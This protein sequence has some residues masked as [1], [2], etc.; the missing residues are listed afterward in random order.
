MALFKL[1]RRKRESSGLFVDRS[2][3]RYM[4]LSGHAGSYKVVRSAAG[5]LR[6][7]FASEGGSFADLGKRL[8]SLFESIVNDMGEIRDP[9]NISLPIMD[10]LLRTVSLGDMDLSEAKLAFRY[11]HEKYFPFPV[12]EA[13]YDMAPILYPL[14]NGAEEKRFLVASARRTLIDDIMNAA[15]AQGIDIAS[16]EPAQLALERAATPQTPFCDAAVY[17]YAGLSYSV[18]ILSWKGNGI[19]YRSVLRG[20]NAA[21]GAESDGLPDEETS[22][23]GFVKEINSSMQFALSQI[24]GFEPSMMF[25]FGPGVSDRLCDIMKKH[26][27]VASVTTI[28][29]LTVHGIDFQKD[30]ARA[31][32][33]EIPVGLALRHL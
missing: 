28:D 16:I 14:P 17:V 26:V 13:V 25:L 24:R 30:D 8:D 33:W 20:Y 10:S 12:D 1:K 11:E 27:T 7:D 19:F 31:G 15:L 3:Y 6:G 18:I 23:Y 4:A 9:V 32:S 29:P 5:N 21:G 22:E 2:I